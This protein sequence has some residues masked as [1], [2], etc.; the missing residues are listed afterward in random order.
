M[1]SQEASTGKNNEMYAIDS[2][3]LHT[4]YDDKNYRAHEVG[5]GIRNSVRGTYETN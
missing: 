2:I 4:V 3:A 1:L 5:D